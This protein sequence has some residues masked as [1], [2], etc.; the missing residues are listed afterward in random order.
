MEHTAISDVDWKRIAK[1][2][3]EI[4]ILAH[5]YPSSV[6]N[7]ADNYFRAPLPEGYWPTNYIE[8]YYGE[9]PEDT[10]LDIK[11]LI[12]DGKPVYELTHLDLKEPADKNVVQVLFDG[13][14]VYIEIEGKIA[15]NRLGGAILPDVLIRPE[16][17]LQMLIKAVPQS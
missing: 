7:A 3:S 14:F 9:D 13:D 10:S 11:C 15:L 2:P 8:V 5:K 12:R 4:A 17:M 16:T 6:V 1:L